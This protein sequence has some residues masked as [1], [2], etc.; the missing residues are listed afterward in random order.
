MLKPNKREDYRKRHVIQGLCRKCCEPLFSEYHCFHHEFYDTLRLAGL[1]LGVLS[2]A[3]KRTRNLIATW[4]QGR[5]D[6]VYR[7]ESAP[8]TREEALVTAEEFRRR[9]NNRWGGVRGVLKLA[10]ILYRLE[11]TAKK[12]RA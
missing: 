9:I 1:T 6:G 11:Q 7:G 2:P 12:R 3:K 8:V 5:Y 10:K 4:M